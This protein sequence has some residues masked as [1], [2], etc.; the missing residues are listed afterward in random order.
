MAQGIYFGW[1]EGTGFCI[2]VFFSRS[3]ETGLGLGEKIG[4][5]T[6]RKLKVEVGHQKLMLQQRKQFREREEG[7][8][9]GPDQNMLVGAEP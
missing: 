2:F 7:E 6:F 8:E 4:V 1:C 5:E 3:C 9:T